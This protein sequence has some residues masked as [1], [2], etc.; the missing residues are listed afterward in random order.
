MYDAYAKELILGKIMQS[1]IISVGGV[2]VSVTYRSP[3]VEIRKGQILEN[4]K[5]WTCN[6]VRHTTDSLLLNCFNYLNK[7]IINMLWER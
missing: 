5:T 3:M 6:K 2:C 7:K 1:G 4:E